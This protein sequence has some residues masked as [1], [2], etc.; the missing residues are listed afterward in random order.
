MASGN[1]AAELGIDRV[2]L[3][4]DTIH[5]NALP[6]FWIWFIV[7]LLIALTAT[8]GLGPTLPAG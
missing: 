6:G 1:A 3:K 7:A 4:Y 8:V 5:L 2:S